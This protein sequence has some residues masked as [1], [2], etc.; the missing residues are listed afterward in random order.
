MSG[1][2]LTSRRGG[3][4]RPRLAG[5]PGHDLASH[6]APP[7]GSDLEF[8]FAFPRAGRYGVWVQVRLAGAVRTAAFSAEVTEAR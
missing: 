3:S 6:A 4:P 8:P 5:P 1:D 2:T 7:A